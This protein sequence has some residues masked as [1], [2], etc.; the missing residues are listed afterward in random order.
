MNIDKF[1]HHVHK[2]LRLLEF[3]DTL[4]DTLVK[5]DAGHYDLKL[6]KLKGLSPPNED[7]EAVNKAYVDKIEQDLRNEFKK[8]QSDVKLYLQN[9]EKL[10][11]DRLLK[12]I[13]SKAEVDT[14]IKLKLNQK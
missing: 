14:L 3:V 12:N 1:G 13:Y 6:S 9:L 2:R 8:I 5:S 10:T 7:D 11:S 4:N